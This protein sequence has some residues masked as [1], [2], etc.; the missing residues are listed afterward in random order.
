MNINWDMPSFRDLGC[1]LI[2][3]HK[4]SFVIDGSS[5]NGVLTSIIDNP[6]QNKG[7]WTD[8]VVGRPRMENIWRVPF[9][10]YG[11]RDAPRGQKDKSTE[12]VDLDTIALKAALDYFRMGVRYPDIGRPAGT[13]DVRA[14]PTGCLCCL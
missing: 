6:R 4:E 3:V 13:A 8:W 14:H 1:N 2:I 11:R 12:G 9:L 10:V 5:P 7:I